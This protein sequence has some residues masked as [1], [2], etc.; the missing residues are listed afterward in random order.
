MIA[1]LK[2]LFKLEPTQMSP[3]QQAQQLELAA[4][5]LLME[6]V[7][8]DEDFSQSEAKLLP[9]MLTTSFTISTEDAQ[10]LIQDA[11]QKR[12]DSISLFE[13]TDLI[14]EHFDLQK[15]LALLLSMWKLAYADGTLCQ[16]EDQIIR[17]TADLLY[18]KHS[19]LMQTRNQA[20]AQVLG[21]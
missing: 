6:V 14:N 20:M 15:K 8:A 17:K 18:L 1:K 12:Q 21:K 4:A 7:Y 2:Q 16:Y 9:E 13:F 19:E 11:T 3:E 10:A 5:S